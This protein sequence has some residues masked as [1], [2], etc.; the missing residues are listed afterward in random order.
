MALGA[1]A[2]GSSE[3]RSAPAPHSR[4]SSSLRSG[5]RVVLAH[6]QTRARLAANELE[7][8]GLRLLEVAVW[9]AAAFVLFA[10]G[11]VFLAFCVVLLFW[12]TNRLLAAGLVTALFISGGG[13][14]VLMVRAGLAAR[15]KFLAATIAEFEKDRA[16][17]DKP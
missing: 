5:L 2:E 4:S 1:P 11:M 10:I 14:S 6:A 16:R 12:D 17:A 8:Q 3:R 15:P 13:V 9:A 7:E